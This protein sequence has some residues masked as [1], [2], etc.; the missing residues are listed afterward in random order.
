MFVLFSIGGI[1]HLLRRISVR[2]LLWSFL[3]VRNFPLIRNSKGPP[4]SSFEA[5]Q[6]LRVVGCHGRSGGVPPSFHG[7]GV[8]GLGRDM[9]TA[10]LG[11]LI[12]STSM[13]PLGMEWLV[14]VKLQGEKWDETYMVYSYERWFI[15]AI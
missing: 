11:T 15:Y 1:S 5:H 9:D 2:N 13:P 10:R 7:L 3:I 12:L 8:G 4:V 14:L 6:L